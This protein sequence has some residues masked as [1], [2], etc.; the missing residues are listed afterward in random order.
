M[1]VVEHALDIIEEAQDQPEGIA[2]LVEYQVTP[3]TW[4][5]KAISLSH[6][7]SVYGIRHAEV[8]VSCR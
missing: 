2:H 6:I 4:F 3:I 1:S 7:V 5:L 8:F